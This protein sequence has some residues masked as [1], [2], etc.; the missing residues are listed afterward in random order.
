MKRNLLQIR[1]KALPKSPNNAPEI[2]A[3]Y[4]EKFVKDNYG[5]TIRPD[6]KGTM[7]YKHAFECSDFSYCVFG[8]DE[9]IEAALKVEPEN[10]KI[11]MD[12]TFRVCPMGIFEQLLIIYVN[13]YGQVSIINS[14]KAYPIV[15]LRISINVGGSL[16][17]CIADKQNASLL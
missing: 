16:H 1:R 3:A 2:I 13:I 12:G 17:L 8:S 15:I 9:V 10:R 7:F 14:S 4:K 11:Y 5:L 6:G